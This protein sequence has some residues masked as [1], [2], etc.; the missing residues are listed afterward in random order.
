MTTYTLVMAPDAEGGYTVIVPALP[1]CV[2]EG[3]TEDEC[4]A[5][6]RE[7]ISLYLD[8]LRDEG[9]AAPVESA[10]PRLVTVTV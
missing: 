4:I 8:E 6:A 1:G 3:D 2:T 9:Q 5:N 7:A 10:P